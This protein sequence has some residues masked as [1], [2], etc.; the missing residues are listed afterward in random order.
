VT[1]ARSTPH[2]ASELPRLLASTLSG[3]LPGRAAHRLAWPEDLPARLDP[4]DADSYG[5][6]AVLLALTPGRAAV[7]FPLIR[8]PSGAYRHAGQISLPGGERDPGETDTACALRE[9]EEEIGLPSSHVEVLGL[10]T[11][12]PVSV[13]RYRIQPVVGWVRETPRWRAQAGEVEEILSGD[14]DALAREGPSRRV[15]RQRE[16]IV[17]DAPAFAV[18][19]T[20]GEEALIWGAT[21]IILAEFLAVWKKVR[22]VDG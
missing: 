18:P 4:P 22:G 11:P 10:L 8:R 20:G 21:A 1:A 17:L 9:A 3:P 12:V 5:P 6:A 2:P 16:G 14:P 7:S 19:S 15:R 13:S